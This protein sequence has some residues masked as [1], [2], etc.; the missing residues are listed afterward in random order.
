[1][2]ER[3][4]QIIPIVRAV[5][6]GTTTAR[7]QVEAAIARIA[8]K[9]KYHTVLEV[10]ADRALARADAI[11]RAV[12]SGELV[13]Q[14]A[15]VPF[16]V[17]DNILTLGSTTTA[18]SNILKNFKAPYQATVIERLEAEGAIVVAKAN[19][20]SFGHG[21]STENSDFGPSK[22]PHDVTRVPGGSSGGSAAAVALDIVPFALGT[23]TGGSIRQPA[24][25]SGVLGLKPT[26][27]AVSRFGV[28]A[29]A[30]STDTVGPL[31]KSAYDAQLVMDIM[32]GVD[33]R[34]A[35]SIET[36][37]TQTPLDL[38]ELRVGVIKQ[39]M[40]EGVQPEVKA[41]VQAAVAR[42]QA[43]GATVSEIDLP[44]LEL[45]LPAYYII[46]PAEISSNLARYDGIKFGHVAKDANDLSEQYA[47]TR[48]E[49]FNN[50]NIRRI[51]I[52][53]YVLSSGYYDAYYR[54]AQ[55]VRTLIIN[56]FNQAFQNVDILVGP[57]APTTAFKLGEH[58]ADPL[59]MYVADVM[60][61][62]V[63]LAGL[64]AASV[65]VGISAGLPVGMQVIAPQRQDAKVLAVADALMKEVSA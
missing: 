10:V 27:G 23:D 54:K 57:T 41:E 37:R 5:K 13:G 24:S 35:T 64:P 48:A 65:P 2:N 4:S 14:L 29:M 9:E 3:T 21:S 52:G 42:L 18:G 6:A 58:S 19:L 12:Q 53:T 20:D 8:E 22:N 30:S 44:S 59:E 7:Q 60:T 62:G 61:V 49:G 45:A 25:F 1:M 36:A 33:E 43:A 46:V 51:M 26:Y 16:I 56:E 11:D 50:E 38:H 31:A 17:K 39:H 34:D 40:G 55:T 32:S 15:G 28:V 47:Q 63:S